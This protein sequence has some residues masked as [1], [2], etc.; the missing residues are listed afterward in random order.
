MSWAAPSS[1]GAAAPTRRSVLIL[2]WAHVLAIAVVV[3]AVVSAAVVGG[4][5]RSRSD[6]R[7]A[8]C[9]SPTRII[10]SR[11]ARPS[12][13]RATRVT[14]ATVTRTTR[15]GTARPTRTTRN[16]VAWS[17]TSREV[18]STT[19]MHAPAAMEAATSAS[20]AAA[21]TTA[22][23]EGVIGNQCRAKQHDCREKYQSIPHDIPPC[24]WVPMPSVERASRAASSK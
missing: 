19:A 23:G 1:C 7:G 18:A 12:R 4:S 8:I 6:R 16:R 22:P 5:G 15:D 17:R 20:K 2:V 3:T 11:I 14:W 24:D 13:Y 9:G 10:S 21:T